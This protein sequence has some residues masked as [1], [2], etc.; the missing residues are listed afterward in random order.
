VRD[1]G[2]GGWVGRGAPSQRQRGGGEE[3][4]DEGTGKG[5]TF[6]M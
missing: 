5:A 4:W 6:G 2:V 3:L 1:E